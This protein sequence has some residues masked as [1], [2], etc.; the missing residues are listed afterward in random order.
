VEL[1]NVEIRSWYDQ[2]R[3]EELV[4]LLSAR[5]DSISR[6]YYVQSL[7]GLKRFDEAINLI[8]NY[9]RVGNFNVAL[10]SLMLNQI[11]GENEVAQ[12]N[13]YWKILKKPLTDNILN[14][15]SPIN[16]EWIL[17]TFATS[18][19]LMEENIHPSIHT[20]NWLKKSFHKELSDGNVDQ[21]TKII[22]IMLSNYGDAHSIYWM[23]K[24]QLEVSQQLFYNAKNSYKQ[25]LEFY[26]NL[27]PDMH[28][29]FKFV[30]QFFGIEEL[31][32]VFVSK[33]IL[34]DDL[35]SYEGTDGY[36]LLFE[37]GTYLQSDSKWYV[38]HSVKIK[39]DLPIVING[40]SPHLTESILSAFEIL[41]SSLM[42]NDSKASLQNKILYGIDEFAHFLFFTD[43]RVPKEQIRDSAF[44][45]DASYKQITDLYQVPI[46]AVNEIAMPEFRHLYIASPGRVGST[47]LHK[48]LRMVGIESIS[49]TWLTFTLSE[50]AFRGRLS[51]NNARILSKLD[52]FLLLEEKIP[53]VVV[54][55][56]PAHASRDLTDILDED[57]Q[58]I[59]LYRNLPDWIISR[60][61]MNSN[62]QNAIKHLVTTLISHSMMLKSGVLGG[63]LWYEELLNSPHT[64]L[65]EIFGDLRKLEW[66]VPV[67]DVQGGTPLSREILRSR[68]SSYEIDD[69]LRAWK[70]SPGP[71]IARDLSLTG[72][73]I[74]TTMRRTFIGNSLS[75]LQ[76]RVVPSNIY[77]DVDHFYHFLLG[78]LL[79]FL[80][81]QKEFFPKR[82][83]YFP[84]LGSMNRHLAW[85][86]E[87]GIEIKVDS[88]DETET[89]VLYEISCIGWDHPSTY[90]FG[91]FELARDTLLELMQFPKPSPNL[92]PRVLIIDRGLANYDDRAN[93]YN[94]TSKRSIPN[95]P[96]LYSRISPIVH[97]ELVVLEDLSLRDQIE[98][99]SMADIVVAQHG[100]A[101][102]NLVW[103]RPSTWVI[104]VI[105]AQVRPPFFEALA[106]RL[107][108]NYISVKQSN[109]HAEVDIDSLASIILQ[110]CSE[111][112]PI[113]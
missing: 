58:V 110:K 51:P 46:D 44:A 2:D 75:V 76:A 93:S 73:E 7:I 38:A 11:L 3:F 59:F 21:A 68:V 102:S 106:R 96:V 19:F 92:E 17:E 99:F 24:A 56:L 48:M 52:S 64:Q 109:N 104:E 9:G 23:A 33:S 32:Q 54:K 61:R 53:P 88:Q 50:H 78:L 103:C 5:Q 20:L 30:L 112:S 40:G 25:A 77:G 79:P 41:D 98:L 113:L 100:A 65:E 105:D 86:T 71:S 34:F 8:I 84:D 80:V 60:M 18:Y 36:G 72:L 4:V 87:L 12:T 97:A 16:K 62:P 66:Q 107:N 83:Y 95:L 74:S 89:Q 35:K 1:S 90:E 14:P 26:D 15:E 101:L 82:I 27:H 42:P 85:L 81:S 10:A 111:H 63:V 37:I 47:L 6:F 39:E 13:K 67:E 69:Y 22:E 49:E 31:R 57:D 28:R 108:L 70:T 29:V 94:G 91:E 45:K 55:K 43:A